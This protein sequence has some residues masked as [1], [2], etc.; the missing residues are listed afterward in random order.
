M[1]APGERVKLRYRLTSSDGREIVNALE[2][3]ALTVTLGAGELH[4]SLEDVVRE[5]GPGQRGTFLL[6]QAFGTPNPELEQDVPLGEFPEDL[7]PAAG[8]LLEFGLPSGETLAG[9]VVRIDGDTVRV[10]FNHPLAGCDVVFEVELLA[11]GE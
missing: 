7:P 11:V 3:E 5:L 4:P 9:T 1:T 8:Q 10:D 2:G 6:P